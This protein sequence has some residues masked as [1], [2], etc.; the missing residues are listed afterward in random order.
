[1][2]SFLGQSPRVCWSH[3]EACTRRGPLAPSS[4]GVG[5]VMR[6][7]DA[8]VRPSRLFRNPG[9]S[10]GRAGHGRLSP[11]RP[12]GVP[13]QRPSRRISTAKV[14]VQSKQ[15]LKA[16]R[17]PTKSRFASL[18][19]ASSPGIM[20]GG[21]LRN[22]G[23]P[24]P[25]PTTRGAAGRSCAV[26]LLPRSSQWPSAETTPPPPPPPGGGQ[27]RWCARSSWGRVTEGVISDYGCRDDRDTPPDLER[28]WLT[29]TC[30]HRMTIPPDG[31]HWLQGG[32]GLRSRPAGTGCLIGK[33]G[34]RRV[35]QR[36]SDRRTRAQRGD[37]TL[38]TC[39]H[40]C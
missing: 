18:Q 32:T 17:L 25:L 28:A 31:Q 10:C 15:G 20:Q 16:R 29:S 33:R 39:R 4:W 8:L 23:G 6:R 38:T 5:R 7:P 40:R 37:I 22:P 24:P 13:L 30:D 27:M 19:R 3:A 26:M 35:L 14:G 34:A 12:H 21:R 36:I 11:A 1:M 9:R 2:D